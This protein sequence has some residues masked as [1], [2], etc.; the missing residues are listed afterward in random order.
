MAQRPLL[1]FLE[2]CK[3]YVVVNKPAG[4]FSQLPDIVKWRQNHG[5]EHL[6][7]LMDLVRSCAQ[8]SGLESSEWRTVHRLDTNVTGGL[9]IAK[10]KNSAAH[11]SKNLKKGGNSGYKLVRKYVALIDGATRNLPTKGVLEHNGMKSW[12]RK[13]DSGALVLQL[14]TGKKHQIRLQ[15]ARGLG[16]PIM[17]DIKYRGKQVRSAG[18]QIGLHSALIQ[19][20]VGLQKRKHLIPVDSGRTSLWAN[21]VDETGNFKPAVQ[22]IL[23]E[24]WEVS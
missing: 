3:T 17:N 20:Q 1:R 12:F 5:D 16:V 11:F 15:L 24:D 9:L 19:T 14:C 21:Y 23:L 22:Q 7:L 2:V 4:V 13:I 18:H 6:P 10:D 8:E